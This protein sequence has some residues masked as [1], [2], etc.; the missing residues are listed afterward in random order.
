MRGSP[1]V[2]WEKPQGRGPDPEHFPRRQCP[3]AR[4]QRL[5]PPREETSGKQLKENP[6][7]YL[8]SGFLLFCLS[9]CHL[10][11]RWSI[12]THELI[13]VVLAS[14]SHSSSPQY[15]S[16]MGCEFSQQSWFNESASPLNPRKNCIHFISPTYRPPCSNHVP[17]SPVTCPP[18][19]SCPAAPPGTPQSHEL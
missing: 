11:Q 5:L 19:P 18:R 14:A 9:L 1:R 13:I 16:P 15:I 3:Q 17:S 8:L 10:L 12:N 4:Q 6:H 2:A 7:P